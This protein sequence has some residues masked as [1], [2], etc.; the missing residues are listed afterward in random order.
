MVTKNFA[1]LILEKSITLAIK[2]LDIIDNLHKELLL[3]LSK[4]DYEK[5]QV[6]SKLDK[7]LSKIFS[8]KF[9]CYLDDRDLKN[10][11]GTIP[12]LKEG[13]DLEPIL[14]EGKIQ[15]TNVAIMHIIYGIEFVKLLTP[16]ELTA[17]LLHEIGHVCYDL[18]GIWKFLNT[19]SSHITPILVV[20]PF[21]LIIQS[22]A[23]LAYTFTSYQKE[24][25][26]DSF[27]VD[28]GYGD[29]LISALYKFNKN[30][31]SP[32]VTKPVPFITR[33]KNFLVWFFNIGHRQH[34]E[35]RDRICKMIKQMEEKYNDDYNVKSILKKYK[36]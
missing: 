27:A 1:P 9:K 19:V 2:K 22:L 12:E 36:C 35:T 17:V 20:I 15:L 5:Q 18:K 16:T 10:T 7:T 32:P 28:Y 13:K 30:I 33:F 4:S 34:P 29:E 11:A 26:A 6:L 14:Q 25:L 8:T 23:S 24:Y 31:K 21:Y 3:S